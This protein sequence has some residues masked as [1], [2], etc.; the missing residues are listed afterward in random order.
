MPNGYRDPYKDSLDRTEE[1]ERTFKQHLKESLL[2]EGA[3]GYV[4][5]P[6]KFAKKN[7]KAFIL[8]VAI[9]DPQKE[10]PEDLRFFI[11][12]MEKLQIKPLKDDLIPIQ[13]ENIMIR[14]E[15]RNY[16]F[17]INHPED[18]RIPAI[19]KGTFSYDDVILLDL[20]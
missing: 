17:E 13:K 1:V 19:I 16:R 2:E 12:P 3:M 15:H 7:G 18:E 10:H 20:E 5:G 8:G 4:V 9:L 14:G 6:T 11:T